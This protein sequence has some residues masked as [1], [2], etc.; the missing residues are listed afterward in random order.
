MKSRPCCCCPFPISRPISSLSHLQT[1]K[2]LHIVT[3]EKGTHTHTFSCKHSRTGPSAAARVLSLTQTQTLFTHVG[4]ESATHGPVTARRSSEPIGE[5]R[6]TC[7]QVSLL[8]FISM[9]TN[10]E[11]EPIHPRCLRSNFLPLPQHSPA[12]QRQSLGEGVLFF[13]W[14]FRSKRAEWGAG[15][16]CRFGELKV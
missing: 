2:Y 6:Q 1:R 11:G 15:R 3:S 10:M 5:H 8:E 12:F 7:Q 14:I 4:Q 16:L 13:S 9:A